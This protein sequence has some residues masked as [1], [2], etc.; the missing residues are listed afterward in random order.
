MMYSSIA[1]CRNETIAAIRRNDSDAAYYWTLR[2][3]M[4]LRGSDTRKEK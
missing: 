4:Y 3:M 2:T 1:F